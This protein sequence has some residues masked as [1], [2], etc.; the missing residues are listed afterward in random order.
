MYNVYIIA[1]MAYW[2]NG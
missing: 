2:E 1:G